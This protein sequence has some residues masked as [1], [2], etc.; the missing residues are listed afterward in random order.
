MTAP[1]LFAL[2]FD[3]ARRSRSQ[4][5]EREFLPAAL[6]IVETPASP[7]SRVIGYV[8]VLFFALALAWACLGQVDVIATARGKIIPTGRT[9][10]VQPLE[11][12]TVRAIHVQEGQPVR[13]G[14]PLIELDPT[15]NAAESERLAADLV[16]AG[17]DAA[18][19]RAALSDAP[20]PVA[21]FDPPQGADALKVRLYRQ[22]LANQVAEQ[23][24]KLAGLDRQYAQRDADR[25]AV[26]GTVAKLSAAIPMLRERAQTKRYLADQGTAS[27]MNA[28]ELEQ[29]LTEYQHEL[30][31]QKSRLA[32]AEAALGAIAESRAQAAAEY[33]RTMLTD[34]TG[35]EQKIAGLTQ[36]LVKATKKTDLQR[37]TSPVDGTVQQLAVHTI[38]GVVTP[39]QTL[40]VIVP[41]D[42]RLEVEAAVENKDIGFVAEG[43]PVEIKIETFN[44]TK[45]GLL[46]GTVTQLSRDSIVPERGGASAD[47]RQPTTAP[48][49]QEPV[50]TARIS[51]DRES[52]EIDGRIIALGPGMSVTAE[53]K[54]GQRRV[55]E[56]L[57]SPVLKYSHES[58]RER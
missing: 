33:Q 15:T 21:T 34:L 2:P 25:A 48:T 37:L 43:N 50:Y 12:G 27:R 10:V 8:I 23:R 9:K 42:S 44:F 11:I 14:D 18:R 28:L 56:Y 32:E 41:R 57:L 55:I 24:A 38:G 17:L 45:Y 51:L 20:D 3:A 58:I 47:P 26:A 7:A 52:M 54:T 46:R 39:A 19:L 53:I 30:L 4:A 1:K 35:A 49:T 31:V 5:H 16:V 36:E 22:L 40:M 6:E 13:A 29:S